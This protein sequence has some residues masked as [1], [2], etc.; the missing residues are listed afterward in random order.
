MQTY[1]I[2]GRKYSIKIGGVIWLL[3]ESDEALR[4]E[5]KRVNTLLNKEEDRRAYASIFI[6]TRFGN[7]PELWHSI[8]FKKL[9]KTNPKLCIDD[10]VGKE[11]RLFGAS[12]PFSG[13]EQTYLG[14]TPVGFA[15]L[16]IV[17]YEAKFTMKQTS[18]L[19]INPDAIKP[20]I[21]KYAY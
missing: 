16:E 18:G 12:V 14:F 19:I 4:A 13:N 21:E 10:L 11:I 6:T 17:G 3:S 15:S 1:N 20:I 7:E 2:E 8:S 9:K 5:V